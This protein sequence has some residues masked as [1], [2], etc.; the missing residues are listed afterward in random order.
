[1]WLRR[2]VRDIVL[3]APTS[4]AST[5]ETRVLQGM[6]ASNSMRRPCGQGAIIPSTRATAGSFAPPGDR[7]CRT[8]NRIQ[9]LLGGRDHDP[10]ISSWLVLCARQPRLF[11]H[12][13]IMYCH[14]LS[15]FGVVSPHA[16]SPFATLK[17]ARVKRPRQRR[18]TA[19]DGCRRGKSENSFGFW[20]R[21]RETLI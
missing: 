4:V 5:G 3:P 2:S 6:N 20:R 15:G 8:S 13:L 11:V 17:Y 21:C 16:D 18:N 14:P 1:M 9:I 12:G 7:T 19:R 10:M